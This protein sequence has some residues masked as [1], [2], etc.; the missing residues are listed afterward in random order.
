ME[1]LVTRKHRSSTLCL[2][3]CAILAVPLCLNAQAPPTAPTFE[4]STI[5]PSKPDTPNSNLSVNTSRV[6]LQ[7]R[8]L[9]ALIQF[10]YNLDHGS[11]DQIIGGPAWLRTS[12]FDINTKSDEATVAEL[13]KMS[14]DERIATLRLM[15]Q[16]L[17]A[18]RFHLNIH[19]ETRPLMV[20][21]LT[22][23][24]PG[25]KTD[26][27]LTNA[28][29]RST[30]HDWRGVHSDRPG[31]IEAQGVPIN[32]LATMLAQQPEIGGRLVIDQTGLTGIYDFTL[33]WSPQVLAESAAPNGS[34]D[35]SGPSL[36]AALTEQLGLKLKSTKAPID[37]V[38]IDH[39]DPPTPN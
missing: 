16:A 32:M 10:A 21:V 15:V 13:S 37:V 22:L 11:D 36:F 26:S 30:S 27:K 6:T 12:R 18:D 20:V 14:Q 29:D 23:A 7:N 5:K 39:V 33:N 24:N 28:P 17:L 9:D 1:Y 2:I 31:H 38:V 8:S 35:P 19:H 3:A 34:S 25:S 4:V